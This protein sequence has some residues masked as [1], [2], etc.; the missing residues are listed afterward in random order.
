MSGFYIGR[1]KYDDD[2][3]L[4]LNQ[5]RVCRLRKVYSS[6]HGCPQYYLSTW[7]DRLNAA[8]LTG[9]KGPVD[10]YIKQVNK[11][12]FE[13]SEARKQRIERGRLAEKERFSTR[14]LRSLKKMKN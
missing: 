4:F 14:V 12:M 1:I 5:D 13:E 3:H 9:L 6:R 2:P 8:A 11:E 7:D 10:A